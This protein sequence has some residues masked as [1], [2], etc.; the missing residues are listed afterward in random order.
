ML[1]E[2]TLL[3]KII[4][5]FFDPIFF[6]LQK[7]H[8]LEREYKNNEKKNFVIRISKTYEFGETNKRIFRVRCQQHTH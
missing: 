4:L 1:K 3:E 6:Y 7:T 8:L 2:L 5:L